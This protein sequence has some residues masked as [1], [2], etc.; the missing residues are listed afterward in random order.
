[1][2]THHRVRPCRRGSWG[3]KAAD[4]PIAADGGWHH[5]RFEEAA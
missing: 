5:P 4:A 3:P 1:M 2:K